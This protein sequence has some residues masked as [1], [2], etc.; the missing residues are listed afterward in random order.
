MKTTILI[1]TLNRLRV[2]ITGSHFDGVEPPDFLRRGIL[3]F[4]AD[5]NVTVD[6]IE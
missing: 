5:G 3:Q 1:L 2:T 6:S 4:H